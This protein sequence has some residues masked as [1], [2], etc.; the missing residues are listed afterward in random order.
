M[1]I[2]NL[3]ITF[4][5]SESSIKSYDLAIVQGFPSSNSYH[6]KGFTPNKGQVKE[7]EVIFYSRNGKMN[8]FITQKGLSYVIYDIEEKESTKSKDR[9]FNSRERE[10][11]VFH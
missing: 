4:N 6:Y 5:F 7:K 9:I 8:I 11:T 2:L 3:I 1:V 10:K